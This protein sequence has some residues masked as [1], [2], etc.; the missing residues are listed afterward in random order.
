MGDL[1]ALASARHQAIRRQARRLNSHPE[2]TAVAVPKGEPAE[3]RWWVKERARTTPERPPVWL[4]KRCAP[5]G[6]D[7]L[8]PEIV[9]SAPG[10]RPAGSHKPDAHL[11]KMNTA[12]TELRLHVW[13][14]G[15]DSAKRA[16][17][18]HQP[19]DKGSGARRLPAL[20][21]GTEELGS[22][23]YAKRRWTAVHPRPTLEHRR[24]ARRV[25]MSSIRQSPAAGRL[26]QP[27]MTFIRP[28]GGA[29]RP[30]HRKQ[31]T[32]FTF[33]RSIDDGEPDLPSPSTF[34]PRS[35]QTSAVAVP[36]GGARS[37]F[38]RRAGKVRRATRIENRRRSGVPDGRTRGR[39]LE[40]AQNRHDPEARAPASGR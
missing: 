3:P 18:P 25:G 5:P 31:R 20:R 40:F 30:G 23:F 36:S 13:K 29:R 35:D 27:G 21:R 26:H 19:G 32:S 24:P 34:D 9:K 22:A 7:R 38:R 2:A 8:E 17:S 28:I 15:V 12:G 1:T 4:G 37:G 14:R 39:R 6:A 10:K 11:R 33:G 16:G